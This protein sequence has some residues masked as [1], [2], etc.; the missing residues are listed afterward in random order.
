LSTTPPYSRLNSMGRPLSLPS[1][2][3]PPSGA[4]KKVF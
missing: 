3:E 4:E 2:I 1:Q